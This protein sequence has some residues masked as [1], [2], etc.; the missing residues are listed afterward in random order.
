MNPLKVELGGSTP[1]VLIALQ[2]Y[3]QT[4]KYHT[5]SPSCHACFDFINSAIT[6]GLGGNRNDSYIN[7]PF[8]LVPSF[9]KGWKAN[10]AFLPTSLS[11]NTTSTGTSLSFSLRKKIELQLRCCCRSAAGGSSTP[12]L[13]GRDW[14]LLN[15]AAM[16]CTTWYSGGRLRSASS[17]P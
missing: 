15:E 9:M 14:G 3:L 6:A 4:I 7:S 17:S 12:L 16:L 2:N 13:A 1:A 5:S 11:W 8:P 10:A